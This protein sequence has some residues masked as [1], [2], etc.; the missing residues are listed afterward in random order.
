MP[1]IFECLMLHKKPI[2]LNAVFIL[3]NYHLSPSII[4]NF[5]GY[6]E[7]TCYSVTT[8]FNGKEAPTIYPKT[9]QV[10]S[11]ACMRGWVNE[12]EEIKKSHRKSAKKKKKNKVK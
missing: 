9:N 4:W 3:R 10:A 5:A 2:D 6:S 11:A 7:P 12:T 1:F 8:S